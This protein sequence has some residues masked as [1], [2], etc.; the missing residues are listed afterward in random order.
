ML[1]RLPLGFVAA[2]VWIGV[3]VVAAQAQTH[4]PTET[5]V[6]VRSAEAP[7]LGELKPKKAAT[8]IGRAGELLFLVRPLPAMETG[9]KAEMGFGGPVAER[10][11]PMAEVRRASGDGILHAFMSDLGETVEVPTSGWFC[12]HIAA[13]SAVPDPLRRAKC[14]TMLRRTQLADGAIAAFEPCVFGPCSVALRR[15]DS[16]S[17]I[18]VEGVLSGRMVAGGPA[19]VLLLTTRWNRE[20]GTW[21][22]ATLVPVALSGAAPSRLPDIALDEVDAREAAQVSA[23]E[24]KVEVTT[25]EPGR[26]LVRVTGRRLVRARADGREISSTPIDEE[27]RIP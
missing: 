27:H 11:G 21:T 25:P 12:E 19:G 13:T 26:S 22:G 16:V 5:M 18:D 23:R 15:G 6:L 8:E 24:V 20:K 2:S 4:P 9:W 10:S 1:N 7:L 3:S 17:T 14:P